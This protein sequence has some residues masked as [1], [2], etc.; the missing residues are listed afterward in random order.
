MT[1]QLQAKYV[2]HVTVM[3][4]GEAVEYV[5][6]ISNTKPTEMKILEAM[7][8]MQNKKLGKVMGS[9]ISKTYHFTNKDSKEEAE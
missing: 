5:V 3:V 8:K 1:Q 4:H 6:S 9:R 7:R 2:I